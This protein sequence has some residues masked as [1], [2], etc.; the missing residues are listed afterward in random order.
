MKI[1]VL[2]ES[3]NKKGY[4]HLLAE[5]FRQGAEGA[6]YMETRLQQ[7]CKVMFLQETAVCSYFILSI[8]KTH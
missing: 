1:V 4:T 5:C 6:N 3:P 2:E 8:Q 7:E